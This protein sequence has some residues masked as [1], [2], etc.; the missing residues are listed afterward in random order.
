MMDGFTVEDAKRFGRLL[1]RW[2][3]N[4]GEDFRIW[5]MATVEETGV[6]RI[7]LKIGNAAPCSRFCCAWHGDSEADV[8]RKAAKTLLGT[9]GFG[10][11]VEEFELLLES[12]GW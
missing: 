2:A 4:G 9:P 7:W 6:D 8:F 10:D 3:E 11:S 1:R 5:R 12:R